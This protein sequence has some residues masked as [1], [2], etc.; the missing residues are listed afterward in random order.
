M[1]VLDA[2]L[3]DPPE[4]IPTMID[5]W[6]AGYHV[7]Y[8]K[9]TARQRESAAK[10]VF[11]YVFYRFLRLLTNVDIPGGHRGFLPD[12]SQGRRCS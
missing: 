11:A 5:K 6:R 12:G 3:Q 9:H 10:K 1:I 4:L 8:A 7:V 2:D